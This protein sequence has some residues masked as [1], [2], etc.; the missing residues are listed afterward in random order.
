MVVGRDSLR[1]NSCPLLGQPGLFRL[2]LLPPEKS[3][4]S[5]EWLVHPSAPVQF[6]AGIDVP[7]TVFIIVLVLNSSLWLTMTPY[8]YYHIPDINDTKSVNDSM[9]A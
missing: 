5:M 6:S 1:I 7:Q 8:Y 4:D 3:M 9:Q 2:R